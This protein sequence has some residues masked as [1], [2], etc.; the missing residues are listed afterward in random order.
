MYLSKPSTSSSF[1]TSNRLPSSTSS[2]TVLSAN[3]GFGMASID[4]QFSSSLRVFSRG[5]L[6][7]SFEMDEI[8]F[9]F[10][11]IS[12]AS[13]ASI[14]SGTVVIL[15]AERLSVLSCFRPSRAV[16][17]DARLL[18]LRSSFDKC[19]NCWKDFGMADIWLNSS[20]S[21]SNFD[22]FPMSLGI[23]VS[24]FL[25][26]I[27]VF[28]ILNEPIFSGNS[29]ILLFERSSV[30]RLFTTFTSSGGNFSSPL[31][32]KESAPVFSAVSM[33]FF[34]APR[35]IP[36]ASFLVRVVLRLR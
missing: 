12:T 20:D 7:I 19:F 14:P 5:H 35:L 36:H 13:R 17:N 2:D 10:R 33:C 11:F 22:N 18:L 26:K 3:S 34:E 9:W 32:E 23:L 15:F 8:W 31:S 16:G 1:L 30:R 6:A 25:F 24:L 27:R 4:R 28:N 21:D 29:D